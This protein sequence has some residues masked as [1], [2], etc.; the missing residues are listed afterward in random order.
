[1]P[2]ILKTDTIVKVSPKTSKEVQLIAFRE[3][4]RWSGNS[5]I[6]QFEDK[7]YLVCRNGRLLFSDTGTISTS[8]RVVSNTTAEAVIFLYNLNR[9]K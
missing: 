4:Y 8:H 3:G 6:I 1:M 5:K 9:T 7:P 2:K